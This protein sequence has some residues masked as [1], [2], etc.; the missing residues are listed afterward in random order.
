[1]EAIEDIDIALL[2]LKT[3]GLQIWMATIAGLL[4]HDRRL[5]SRIPLHEEAIII[6]LT[7]KL[8]ELV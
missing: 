8:D 3:L 1:M 5:V 4:E 6:C 7:S 2:F